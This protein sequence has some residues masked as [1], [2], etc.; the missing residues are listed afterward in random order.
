MP[1][2]EVMYVVSE[3]LG[4]LPRPQHWQ[5]AV[6]VSHVKLVEAILQYCSI[7]SDRYSDTT[8]LLHKTAVRMNVYTHTL[9]IYNGLLS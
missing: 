3:I 5:F 2:A 6:L 4:E 9:Y 8:A 7:P 1:D